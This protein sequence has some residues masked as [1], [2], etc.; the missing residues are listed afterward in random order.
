MT[1]VPGE[2]HVLDSLGWAYFKL[3]KY[4]KAEQYLVQASEKLKSATVYEH[5]GNLYDKL[6]KKDLAVADWQKALALL[7]EPSDLARLKSKIAAAS[8]K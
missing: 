8:N 4:D 5:L 7:T 1:V 2:P 3:G 6:D